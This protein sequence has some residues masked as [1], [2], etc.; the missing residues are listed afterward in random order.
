MNLST[1]RSRVSGAI[2]LSNASGSS[3]QSLIDGWINEGIVDFLR[4]TKCHKK[5]LSMNLTASEWRYTLDTDILSFEKAWLDSTNSLQDRLLQPIDSAEIFRMRAFENPV[6]SG[7]MYYSL[8]G[9]HLLLL[10]PVPASSADT[11]NAVYVPRP[12]ALAVTAD[13]P[14]A[15]A[16]G[17]IPEEFHQFIEAYAKWKAGDYA[18][19]SSSGNGQVYMQEYMAGVVE[20]TKATQLKAGVRLSGI[21]P[22]RYPRRGLTPVTPGTDLKYP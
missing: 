10:H 15:T 9:A 7:P 16:N 6:G 2:G 20:A 4:R 12:A 8:E 18:D 13:T 11:F 22:G 19:D 17:G 3:E 14:S 21:V 5:L 1:F